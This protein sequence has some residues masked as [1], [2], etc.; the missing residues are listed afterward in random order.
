MGNGSPYSKETS[1]LVGSTK[2][3]RRFAFDEE[4]MLPYNAMRTYTASL[5][6]TAGGL[7]G[8]YASLLESTTD[9]RNFARV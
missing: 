3:D 8:V 5:H 7:D 1:A 9:E 4:G 6:Q 2:E